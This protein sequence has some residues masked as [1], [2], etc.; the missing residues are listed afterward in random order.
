MSSIGKDEQ[1]AGYLKNRYS[2][3]YRS[4]VFDRNQNSSEY[5]KGVFAGR[6]I[7]LLTLLNDVEQVKQIPESEFLEKQQKADL[8]REHFGQASGGD[9]IKHII[10]KTY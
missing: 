1:L 5:Q 9:S 2:I 4:A 6:V 7:E 10:N 3:I 8:R